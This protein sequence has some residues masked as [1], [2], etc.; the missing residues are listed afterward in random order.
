[1]GFSKKPTRRQ[2]NRRSRF[3]VNAGTAFETIDTHVTFFWLSTTPRR[4]IANIFVHSLERSTRT[5]GFWNEFLL[6]TLFNNGPFIPSEYGTGSRSAWWTS[7]SVDPH[8]QRKGTG[9]YIKEIHCQ[10]LSMCSRLRKCHGCYCGTRISPPRLSPN[11]LSR[12]GGDTVFTH[13]LGGITEND[14]KLAEKLD[15][16]KIVYSPK[17]LK[18]NP[19]AAGTSAPQE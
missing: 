18:S 9:V 13:K 16:V 6:H 5:A 8:L 1:M 3:P 11:K 12:R 15:M 4:S 19:Q 10:K 14:L 2:S 17:W 7:P